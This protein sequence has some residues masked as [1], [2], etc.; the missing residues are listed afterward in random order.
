MTG[1]LEPIGAILRRLAAHRVDDPTGEQVATAH[2]AAVSLVSVAVDPTG[3]EVSD[4]LFSDLLVDLYAAGPAHAAAALI[5]LVIRAVDAL[6]LE[7]GH[8]DEGFR[9]QVWAQILRTTTYLYGDDK[10]QP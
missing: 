3:A 8:A 4:R 10:E 5:D 6:L 2:A 9:P 1:E 7:L